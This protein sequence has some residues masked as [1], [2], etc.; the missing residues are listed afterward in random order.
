MIRRKTVIKLRPADVIFKTKM[1]QIGFWLGLCPISC[2][3]WSFRASPDLITEL[4]GSFFCGKGKMGKKEKENG[5]AE[6]ESK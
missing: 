1:H 6:A 2:C 3:K 5:E 4:K